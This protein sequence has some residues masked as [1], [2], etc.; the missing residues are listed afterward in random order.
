MG[1]SNQNEIRPPLTAPAA[2]AVA[3]FRWF[4][5]GLTDGDRAV[6]PW[7]FLGL[8]VAAVAIQIAGAFGPSWSAALIFDR[9]AIAAGQV[10]RLWTGHLVH[11]G[12]PHC[13]VDT[14][15]LL[16]L[17]WVIAWPHLAVRRGALIVLPLFISGAI[18]LFDPGVGYYAGLSA[19]NL[20]LF[21][22]LAIQSWRRDR[23]D[24]LWPA[25]LFVCLGEIALEAARGGS[26]GGLIAFSDPSV[27]IAISA[28]LAGVVGGLVLWLLCHRRECSGPAPAR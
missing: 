17:G 22:F 6:Y 1:T 4:R 14:A 21:V 20:G 8:A 13:A 12:W 15:V 16:Y 23:S 19:L 7:S 5:R 26:G 27:R 25:V 9:D 3:R 24:W 11:F 28:H 2:A 10:W 18:Y